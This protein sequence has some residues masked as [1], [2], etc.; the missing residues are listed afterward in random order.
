M[1]KKI[2][3][4]LVV[5]FIIVFCLVACDDNGQEENPSNENPSEEVEENIGKP[6]VTPVLTADEIKDL[7]KTVPNTFTF[8]FNN[9]LS[10]GDMNVKSVLIKDNFYLKEETYKSKM[11]IESLNGLSSRN[12]Y[13]FD[14]NDTSFILYSYVKSEDKYLLSKDYSGKTLAEIITSNL[15]PFEYLSNITDKFVYEEGIYKL[16]VIDMSATFNG[17]EVVFDEFKASFTL[18]N[19]ALKEISGSFSYPDKLCSWSLK[20]GEGDVEIP[21]NA[22]SFLNAEQKSFLKHELNFANHTVF[23]ETYTT[24]FSSIY[25]TYELIRDNKNFKY[26]I[27]SNS[28]LEEDNVYVFSQEDFL[29]KKYEFDFHRNL[30]ALTNVTDGYDILTF[31]NEMTLSSLYFTEYVDD[32]YYEGSSYHL[33]LKNL[34]M[35][36]SGITIAL[37]IDIT[38]NVLDGRLDSIEGKIYSNGLPMSVKLTV[39]E[40]SVKEPTYDV[41]GYVPEGTVVDLELG[42]QYTVLLEKEYSTYSFELEHGNR[43]SILVAPSN[44]QMSVTAVNP[45]QYVMVIKEGTELYKRYIFNVSTKHSIPESVSVGESFTILNNDSVVNRVTIDDLTMLSYENGVFTCLKAGNATFK[46]ATKDRDGYYVEYDYVITI[47]EE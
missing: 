5:I 12:I 37:D 13:A 43:D 33:N 21:T 4:I 34:S 11:S 17:T 23:T 9:S 7:A 47:L 24:S 2:F 41:I 10:S 26:S 39:G 42:E 22:P 3:L 27:I 32:F 16:N 20:V 35:Q 40:G 38:V 29:V 18:E 46:I 31:C 45:G 15:I 19:N 30:Y 8:E 36:I 25:M 44:L 28:G 14:E 1:K 6:E